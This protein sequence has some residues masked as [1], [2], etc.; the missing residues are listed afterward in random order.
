MLWACRLAVVW[1]TRPGQWWWPGG[2]A[3]ACL[4]ARAAQCGDGDRDPQRTEW[5]DM[6]YRNIGDGRVG[7]TVSD[8]CLGIM[9]FGYRTDERTAFDILDRFVDAGGT[10]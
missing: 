8:L 5:S 2:S 4:P 3:V 1:P 9:N 6:R 7:L 10:F